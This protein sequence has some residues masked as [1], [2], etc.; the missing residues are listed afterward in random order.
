MLEERR[1]IRALLETLTP[2][3]WAAPSLC[4]AWT[5]RDV[6]AHL[7]AWDDL[8]IYRTPRDHRRALVRFIRLYAVSLASMRRLNR[9]LNAPLDDVP[10]ADL[11]ERFGADDDA[12]L[13][14]L[15]DGSNPGAH[16][17]EYVIHHEDIRRP[18]GLAREAPTDRVAAAID[19]ARRLPGVR[20][21]AQRRRR[22]RRKDTAASLDDLLVAAGRTGYT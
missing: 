7:V 17:A 13:R 18:L 9:R 10:V 1:A 12:E 3:Q 8:I 11:L 14:W 21:Q 6:V 16:Y 5:V 22:L 15:F 2:E 19:G 20:L 4:A